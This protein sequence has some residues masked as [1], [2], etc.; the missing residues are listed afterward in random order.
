MIEF[1]AIVCRIEGSLKSWKLPMTENTVA[2][3]RGAA[4][5]RQLDGEDRAERAGAI[6]FGGLIEILRDRLQRREEDEHVVADEL[7]GDDVSDRDHDQVRG[8]RR[9]QVEPEEAVQVGDEAELRSVHIAPDHDRDDAGDRI[10]QKDRE[11]VE[12]HPAQ[13]RAVEGQRG[14][15]GE[16]AA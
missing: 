11:T 2:M 10:G 16:A 15:E 9:R 4:N 3:I 7:P 6:D 1:G 14:E 13:A 8:H 5:G 12:R